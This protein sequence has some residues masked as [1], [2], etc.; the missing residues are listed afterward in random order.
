MKM[1]PSAKVR[2]PELLSGF[3]NTNL[4]IYLLPLTSDIYVSHLICGGFCFAFVFSIFVVFA[5]FWI[6]LVFWGWGSLR[7]PNL[8][9]RRILW[10]GKRGNWQKFWVLW[11]EE[12]F[13]Y[14]VW[15]PGLLS[16]MGKCFCFSYLYWDL[17]CK[18]PCSPFPS[19]GIYI[20]NIIQTI[21][22]YRLL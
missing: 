11:E 16:V 12:F 17:S 6:F 14:S 22:Y 2:S 19:L 4:G 5:W 13:D 15:C 8:V 1:W 20:T 18:V 7:L 3:V 10:G 21:L 9:Q